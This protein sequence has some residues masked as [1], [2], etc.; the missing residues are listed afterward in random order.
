MKKQSN[1]LPSTKPDHL[2]SSQPSQ[3]SLQLNKP[4]SHISQFTNFFASFRNVHRLRYNLLFRDLEAVYKA[5]ELLINDLLAV[6][7]AQEMWQLL[8]PKHQEEL[9]EQEQVNLLLR[10][11]LELNS[12][13]HKE[14]DQG[15]IAV[16][17]QYRA[18]IEWLIPQIVA[19]ES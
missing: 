9:T 2:Y 7:S 19:F 16:F 3:P 12:R 15:N 11:L 4:R 5:N 6:S 8:V 18:T 10:M 14:A 1:T 17:D 13:K